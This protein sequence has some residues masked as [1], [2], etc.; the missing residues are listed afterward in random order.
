M[1]STLGARTLLLEPNVKQV[2]LGSC[3]IGAVGG[4][5]VLALPFGGESA[6]N[7]P[8]ILYPYPDQRGVPTLY[9]K[10]LPSA[11]PP[12]GQGKPAGCPIT[13]R[14]PWH[15]PLDQA[16]GRL[17]D[18]AGQEVPV[19]MSTTQQP[20]PGVTP[21][22]VCLL[23]R[24]PLHEGE[25]YT[26]TVTAK[27]DGKPWNKT[28]SFTTYKMDADLPALEA[29]ILARLN[30]I[31][32]QAGLSPVELDAA[33]S[34]GC[35]LHAQYLIANEKR[36]GAV[37]QGVQ[38]EDPNYPKAT[39]EGASAAKEALIAPGIPDAMEALDQ[40]EESFYHRLPILTPELRKVG[41]GCAEYPNGSWAVVLD[42]P[43]GK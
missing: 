19:W 36:P 11:V 10:E 39:P 40:W 25:T 35:R 7:H 42:S 38:K 21:F 2:A 16:T 23:P 17:T 15:K 12:E 14:F 43:S 29:A 1:L 34:R 27:F 37:G 33:L 13:V 8:P 6:E 5:W 4:T 24:Q 41:F 9:G 31:R 22:L 28:W 26:A 20:L 30:Q 3:W 18:A 32:K